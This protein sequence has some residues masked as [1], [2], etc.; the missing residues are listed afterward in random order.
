[1]PISL[2]YTDFIYLK[3]NSYIIFLLVKPDL[4]GIH[5]L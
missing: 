5:Y 3:K 2:H 4:I 1:M